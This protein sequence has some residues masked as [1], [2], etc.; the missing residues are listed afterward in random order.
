MRH[1]AQFQ[2]GAPSIEIGTWLHV[3]SI[4][5]AALQRNLAGQGV[6]TKQM[7]THSCVVN[8]RE[9]TSVAAIATDCGYNHLNFRVRLFSFLQLMSSDQAG[10]S[11]LAASVKETKDAQSGTKLHRHECCNCSLMP[12]SLILLV[13]LAPLQAPTQPVSHAEPTSACATNRTTP[14]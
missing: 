11:Q 3:A 13:R 2:K 8:T 9:D 1:K 6:V 5:G 7:E 4:A 10:F 14:V 12:L